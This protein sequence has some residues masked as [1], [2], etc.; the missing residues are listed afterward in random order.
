MWYQSLD[1]REFSYR[2][3]TQQT[4]TQ[5]SAHHGSLI[6]L[7]I[8]SY[9]LVCGSQTLQVSR[10]S[11]PYQDQFH[12]TSYRSWGPLLRNWIWVDND[13]S[14]EF[15]H[16]W[17][18]GTESGILSWQS[19]VGWYPRRTWKPSLWEESLAPWAQPI[20]ICSANKLVKVFT[21]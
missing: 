8:F 1:Y 12:S 19:R 6:Y 2:A 11:A 9:Y 15:Q 4:H 5:I 7:F 14:A 20:C 13:S 10:V 3:H 21:I 18:V 16:L 17:S